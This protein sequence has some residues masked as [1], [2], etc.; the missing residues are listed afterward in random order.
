MSALPIQY[1]SAAYLRTVFD[2][3]LDPATRCWTLAPDGSWSPSPA[4]D[5][6][7]SPVRDHQAEMMHLHSRATGRVAT[8]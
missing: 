6:G 2:S 4:P 8:E 1:S 3:C 7:V 5:S